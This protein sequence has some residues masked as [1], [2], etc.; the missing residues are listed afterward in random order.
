V[1]VSY[2]NENDAAWGSVFW[3]LERIACLKK[4]S[5]TEAHLVN[6]ETMVLSI[7]GL[8]YM[9]VKNRN[10]LIAAAAG[11][12]ESSITRLQTY[13]EE[14]LQLMFYENANLA[15]VLRRLHGCY[16]KSALNIHNTTCVLLGVILKILDNP[17]MDQTQFIAI[18][19]A[20]LENIYRPA[21]IV[22]AS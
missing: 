16:V 21:W 15:R 2:E 1:S 18:Y 3:G 4:N 13:I 17:N 5:I 6:A 14:A 22:K 11:S 10:L 20:I 9:L 7:I 19:D 8:H 12:A